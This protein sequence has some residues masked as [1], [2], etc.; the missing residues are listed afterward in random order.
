M[1]QRVSCGADQAALLK[2]L[3]LLKRPAPWDNFSSFSRISTGPGVYT[4]AE[5]TQRR[6]LSG[7]RHQR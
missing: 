2:L 4:P 6:G 1:S 5:F 7:L 3:I